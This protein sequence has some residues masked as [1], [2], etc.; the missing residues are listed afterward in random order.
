MEK[1]TKDAVNSTFRSC[2]F[3]RPPITG[4][5]IKAEGITLTVGFDPAKIE[6]SRDKIHNFLSQLPSSFNESTGGGYSFLQA[7]ETNNGEQWTDLHRDMEELFLL[8]MAAGYVKCLLPRNM[9]LSLPGCVPYYVVLT[10]P[11]PVEA[12]TL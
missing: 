8:G 3:D 11:V 2:L 7:C 5:Y 1:L 10:D 4:T 9:W 12:T 6:A